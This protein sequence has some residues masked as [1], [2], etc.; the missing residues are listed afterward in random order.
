MSMSLTA[1][2]HLAG[3]HRAQVAGEVSVQAVVDDKAGPWAART[4]GDHTD[5]VLVAAEGPH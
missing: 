4:A 3:P 5:D 2:S 1:L